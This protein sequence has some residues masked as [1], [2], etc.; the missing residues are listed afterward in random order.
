MESPSE[1]RVS[2]RGGA[3]WIQRCRTTLLKSSTNGDNDL[4]PEKKLDQ[5][6]PFEWDKIVKQAKLFWDM[7]IPYFEESKS[8]RWLFAGMI[9]L[10]L[11]NSGVSVAFSYVSKDFW[12]A[13]SA[14]DVEQF[15][16]M[17]TKFAGA[18]LVGAPVSV[19]YRYQRERVAVNWREWMVCIGISVI[20]VSCRFTV[21]KLTFHFTIPIDGSHLATVLLESSLLQSRALQFGQSR[22]AYI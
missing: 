12:N 8:G 22:S 3:S 10:T 6:E 9:G 19:F 7:A 17:L 18:L 1:L 13:L 14:K 4:I 5:P 2:C 16:V 21:S 20:D 11:L 15:Y